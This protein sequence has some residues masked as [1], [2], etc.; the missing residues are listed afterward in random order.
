MKDLICN[1][2]EQ[3]FHKLYIAN[4]KSW[5]WMPNKKSLSKLVV[6]TYHWTTPNRPN[7]HT[8]RVNST[9]MKT[10]LQFV[11]CLFLIL[12]KLLIPGRTSR[13]SWGVCCVAHH[14]WRHCPLPP[15]TTRCTPTPPHHPRMFLPPRSTP[16]CPATAA[17]PVCGPCTSIPSLPSGTRTTRPSAHPLGACPTNPLTWKGKIVPQVRKQL[18]L[19]LW[20]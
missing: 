2:I 11:I 20:L 9:Q 6:L 15:S 1:I 5:L 18:V 16:P 10:S 12:I 13:R 14:R 4:S 17:H 8:K 7:F 3:S 19:K